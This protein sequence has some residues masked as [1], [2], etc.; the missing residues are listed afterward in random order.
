MSNCYFL[1]QIRHREGFQRSGGRSPEP[2]TSTLAAPRLD[3]C[4]AQKGKSKKGK[5]WS[6]PSH[7]TK[8]MWSTLDPKDFWPYLLG[9]P[10]KL[11]KRSGIKLT[12]KWPNGGMYARQIYKYL[13]F[14]YSEGKRAKPTLSQESYLLMRSTCLISSASLF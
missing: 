14:S 10:E 4:S 1:F 2:V 9:I 6:T 3:L 7:C 13:F 12:P 8:L 5:K 11:N